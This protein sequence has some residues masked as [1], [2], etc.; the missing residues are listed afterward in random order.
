MRPSTV[1]VIA[2]L[3]ATLLVGLTV[4]PASATDDRANVTLYHA[5]ADD[6]EDAAALEAAI[7]DGQVVRRQ[8]IPRNDTLVVAADSERLA[9]D[10]DEREGTP[11]ERFFD[12]TEDDFEFR[13][14]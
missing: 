10:L 4:A 9:T 5:A 7:D 14:V 11:T 2:A 12:A 13:F 3:G 8:A 1:F 6:F